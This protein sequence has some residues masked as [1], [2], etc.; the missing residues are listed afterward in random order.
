MYQ[1]HYYVR[2]KLNF[3]MN[4]ESALKGS[5]TATGNIASKTGSNSFAITAITYNNS[6][7]FQKMPKV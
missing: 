7:K 6:S 4:F 2:M 5:D 3:K 1:I